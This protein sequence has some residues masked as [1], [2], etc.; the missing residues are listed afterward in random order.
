M[1]MDDY[2][3]YHM[4]IRKAGG[5]RGSGINGLLSLIK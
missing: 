2:V 1:V 3:N 4:E 5:E